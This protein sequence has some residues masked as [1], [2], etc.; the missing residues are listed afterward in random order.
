MKKVLIVKSSFREVSNS[1]ILID[2]FKLGVKE[3]TSNEV[4][5]INLKDINLKFCLGC[6][7]CQKNG[8]CVIDDDMNKLY[9]LVS[10]SDVLAFASPIYYYDI[11]GQLKTFLDRLNPLYI[12]EN[13]FKEVYL[14]LTSAEEDN[15]V[16]ENAIKTINGWI[17]CF[18]NLHLVKVIKSFGVTNGGDISEKKEDL[19]FAYNLGSKIV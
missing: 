15:E 6:L 3:N 2:S 1:N 10:E 17:E 11:S 14:F 7:A 12:K 9:D 19:L 18:H 16:M 5:E 13:K 8:R 4:N